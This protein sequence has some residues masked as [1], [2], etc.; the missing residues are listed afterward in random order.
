MGGIAVKHGL[1]A[2][3]VRCKQE[4]QKRK[5]DGHILL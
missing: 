1:W 5:P 2:G 4:Q 3:E